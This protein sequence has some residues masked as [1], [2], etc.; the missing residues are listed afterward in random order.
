MN[1]KTTDEMTIKLNARFVLVSS[2]VLATLIGILGGYVIFS[3]TSSTAPTS[4]AVGTSPVRR[5]LQHP[6]SPEGRTIVSGALCPCSCD[7]CR[8]RLLAE[9][10]CQTSTE[11]RG[12]INR[13]LSQNKSK[14]EI[15]EILK[16]RY[17]EFNYV[18]Y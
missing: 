4:G 6:L 3:R 1:N 12:T 2:V 10:D 14:E 17:G 11:I 18:K 16:T 9:C 5:Q 15:R 8:G 13:L 7:Y